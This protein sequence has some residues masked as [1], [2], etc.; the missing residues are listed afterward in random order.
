MIKLHVTHEVVKDLE[1]KRDE[2]MTEFT[3]VMMIK[4]QRHT[5]TKKRIWN[6]EI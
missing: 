4:R 3:K 1:K 2:N 6:D 5:N